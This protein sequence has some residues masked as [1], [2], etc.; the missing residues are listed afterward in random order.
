MHKD[1]TKNTRLPNVKVPES[2]FNVWKIKK[3]HR[4]IKDIS[5]AANRS[6]H[7]IAKALNYGVCNV[8]LMETINQF[9]NN[10]A[11]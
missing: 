6:R 1:K 3:T 7:T 5:I 8:E 4:D 9:Y 10:K 11:V 2:I